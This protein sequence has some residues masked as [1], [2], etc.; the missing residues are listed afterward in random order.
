MDRTSLAHR[1]VHVT[2]DDPDVLLVHEETIFADGRPVGHLTSGDYGHTL[3]RSVCIGVIERSVDLDA[4]F[5][6]RCKGQQHP[7][8]VSTRPFF[9]PDGLRMHAREPDESTATPVS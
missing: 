9:D 1:A 4:D 3:G 5:T 8:T 2:L 7:I 6:V